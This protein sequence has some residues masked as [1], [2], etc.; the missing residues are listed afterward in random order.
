VWVK[1]I[2]VD[3]HVSL[4]VDMYLTTAEDTGDVKANNTVTLRCCVHC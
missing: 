1:F 3:Q 4:G 2:F